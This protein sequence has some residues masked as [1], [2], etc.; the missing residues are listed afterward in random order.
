MPL[1]AIL[2]LIAFA[3]GCILAATRN[4]VYGLMTYMVT[5]YLDPTGQWWGQ[6]LLPDLRWEFIP[7]VITL[8]AM[9]V[10]R[11]R[12]PSPVFRSAAFR[13]FAAFVLLIVIQFPWALDHHS[14][15]HLLTVWA[16]FLLVS[17]MICGCVDSWRNLRLVLWSQFAGCTYMGWTAYVF[18]NGG[19]FQGFGL[20]SIGDANTG[21]VVLVTGFIAAAALFLV[22]RWPL[23]VLLLLGMGF[24]SDGIIMTVSRSGFLELAL[25]STAFLLSTPKAYRSRVTAA[26]ALAVAGFLVLSGAYYWHRI[27]TIQDAGTKIQGVDTGH[28]RVVI[29]KEQFRM[30]LAHPLGGC[31]YGCTEALSPYYIPRQYLARGL[32]KRASHNTF[33]TMLV[34]FGVLG[35][36]LYLSLLAWLYRSLR[37]LAPLVRF[38]DGLP[39]SVFPALVG[40]TVAITIGDLF[41]SLTMLEVRVWFVSILIAYMQLLRLESNSTSPPIQLAQTWRSRLAS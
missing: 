30:F 36:I 18:Y 37:N 24:I 27:Q 19:R 16:K 15:A 14:Q 3:V 34:S 21:A 33:M 38:R 23:K 17:I 10:H 25:G 7:A 1:S 2:F 31:G 39:A 22:E 11:R 12:M 20:N 13:G 35:A 4:P 6:Q 26:A 8:L 29:A 40:V 28:S 41:N 9:L 32:G 5:L